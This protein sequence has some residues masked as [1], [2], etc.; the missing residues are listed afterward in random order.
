MLPLRAAW[1]FSLAAE[2]VRPH[3]GCPQA[4]QGLLSLGAVSPAVLEAYEG[5]QGSGPSRRL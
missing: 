2:I 3:L 1:A 5:P 4:Q